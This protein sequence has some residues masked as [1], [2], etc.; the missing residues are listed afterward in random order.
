V[1]SVAAWVELLWTAWRTGVLAISPLWQITLV[2]GSLV[3]AAEGALFFLTRRERWMGPIGDMARRVTGE[4]A[5][6]KALSTLLALLIVPL[7]PWAVFGPAGRFVEGLFPRLLL[8]WVAIVALG[9]LVRVH[10]QETSWTSLLLGTALAY[11]LLYRI[12]VFLPDLSTYPFSLAWSEASRYYYAS[13]F[14]AQGI[15]GFPVSPSE[16]HPT[17]YLLQSIPFLVSGLPLWVH[18]LWQVLLW[19]SLP[20]VAAGLLVRRLRLEGHWPRLLV[21]A[22]AVLFLFQGPVYYHLLVAVVFV[23]AWVDGSRPWRSTGVVLLASAWAGISRLNWFPVPGILAGCLYVLE[24]PRGR[25]AWHRY[26]RLPVAWVVLGTGVAVLTQAVYVA[27]S[28]LGADRFTSSFSSD[29][30]LYRLLPNAT[31]APG[32]LPAA[33]LASAPMALAVWRT[34]AAWAGRIDRWSGIFLA[35]SLAILFLGGLLVSSKI[36][37]GSNLHNLDAYL[38]LLLLVGGVLAVGPSLRSPDEVGKGDL[39]SS[40]SA[41]L[42]AIPLTFALAMGGPWTKRDAGEAAESLR[43]ITARAQEVA[44]SGS[45]VL[46]ISQRHLLTFGMVEVPLVPEY[47]TVFLMEMAMAGNRP[48]LDPFQA[49]LKSRT[50]G[51][52]VVDHLGTAFQGRSHNFGEENDAWVREVSRPILCYYEPIETLEQPRVDL[53]VP[54][55]EV[56]SCSEG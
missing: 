54:R 1:L 29:L 43:I 39:A 25:E 3:V 52:I 5:R 36:G 41:L 28:G 32:V 18:R 20:A 38:V 4:V 51:L 34:R 14:H 50:F 15:Y 49:A 10:F 46:F 13:L 30:L 27:L 55:S 16:L 19:L 37:G 8:F 24:T 31:Y 12:L 26:F 42:V 9:L 21:T 53:L 17:R 47:E 56:Q 6:R 33:L 48:Y 23:L 40:V 2:A 7:F 45:P 22:W 35:G 44:A 11:G